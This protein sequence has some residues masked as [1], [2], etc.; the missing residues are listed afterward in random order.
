MVMKLIPLSHGKVTMVDDVDFEFLS[1]RKWDAYWKRRNG[2]VVWYAVHSHPR[3]PRT[4]MHRVIAQRV[5]LPW[6]ERYDHVDCDGLNNQR[7]NIRP[8]TVGQNM[9]NSR[10][11]LG[12][13]S[14][15]KGVS[16][17]QRQMKWSVCIGV[18]GKYRFLGRF[19]DEAEAALAYNVAAVET[20]G[21]FAR[22]N[23]IGS[24]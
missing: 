23:V 2:T 3:R 22:V 5:G 10:K 12:C 4:W 21:E 13:S 9:A 6:S 11:R 20:F 8:C 16:W 1:Q 17:H 14:R 19:D 15:Y 18:N 24:D 7:D